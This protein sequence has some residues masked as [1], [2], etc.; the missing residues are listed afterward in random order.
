[1][2]L[3]EK[4]RKQGLGLIDVHV[5]VFF[6]E[7]LNQ[8][9]TKWIE[10][11]NVE[12]AYVSIYPFDL[13]SLNPPPSAV[14]KGNLKVLEMLRKDKRFKGYVFINQLN[15]EDIK[16]A[17]DFLKEGFSGIGEVYR[18]CKLRGRLA[19]PIMNLA[20]EYDVPVLVHTA[21]RLYPKDRPR[22][23]TPQDI[24]NLAKRWPKVRIIMAHIAGGGDWEFALQAV[25]DYE[26]VYVDI[27]GSV[28]DS[29]LVER[30]VDLLGP[31]RVLFASDNLLAQSVGRVE[32]A[33][34]DEDVKIHIYRE[35][36]LKVF[37]D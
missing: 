33:V 17:E 29:G 8:R 6:N 20:K 5:H 21:H 34:L 4:L 28:Q 9:L 1:M 16:N 18:S 3:F 13:G 10:V 19:E 26:N 32:S 15:S 23:M 2:Y 31:R 30:A 12:R 14:Y 25:K 7:E 11:F 24:A 37:R 35:N 27:G 22:E 36:A